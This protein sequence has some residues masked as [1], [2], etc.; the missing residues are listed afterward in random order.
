MEV[1]FF[2]RSIEN[3]KRVLGQLPPEQQPNPC[4]IDLN[5][6]NVLDKTSTTQQGKETTLLEPTRLD[7]QP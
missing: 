7:A 3:T 6:G 5:Q 1:I 4:F 2:T